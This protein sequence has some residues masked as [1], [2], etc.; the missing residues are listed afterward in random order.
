[1]A[2]RKHHILKRIEKLGYG[3]HIIDNCDSASPRIIMLGCEVLDGDDDM[4]PADMYER[5]NVKNSG[6]FGIA[7][8]LIDLANEAGS[9]WGWQ[10]PAIIVMYID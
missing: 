7:Q 5:G 6:D 4:I 9:Y 3:R 8:S 10:N 2:L 1:M